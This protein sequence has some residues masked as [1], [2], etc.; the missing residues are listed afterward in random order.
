MDREFYINC[1]EDLI[2]MYIKENPDATED[3][4]YTA[5][6]GVVDRYARDLLA[7]RAD[8]YRQLAKDS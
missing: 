2:E 1:L 8:F 4:A 6:S 7:D 5:A 3:E